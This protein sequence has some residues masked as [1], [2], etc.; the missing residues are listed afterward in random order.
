MQ[1]AQECAGSDVV[2]READTLFFLNCGFGEPLP[3][4]DLVL[5]RSLGYQGIRQDVPRVEVAG[6]LV[7]NVLAE[8][9]VGIFVIPV[10]DEDACHDIAHA[11]A[12][13]IVLRSG[14]SSCAIEAG[15]EEDLSGKR[16]TR[17]PLGWARLVADVS[18]IAQSHG[19][20]QVV[21]GGVSSLSRHAMG[22]LERSHV[23][24]LQVGVG[25][26]QYR[27][28]PPGEALDGYAWREDE[29]RALR[30]AAGGRD[31]WMTESGWSTA[32]RTAG[33]WPLRKTWAFTDDQVAR[34]LRAEM[35]INAEHHA[36]C[37]VTYQ[38]N[39]GPD[40]SNDQDRFGI[41]RSDG[42]LKPQARVLLA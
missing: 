14:E 4:A 39:D 3:A 31:V 21:S 27:S 42:S 25:Y 16:W 11:V 28:T 17:D 32:K 2:L 15:N 6:E 1:L 10:A 18:I 36:R 20:I 41:R 38:L 19:R 35:S 30:D 29:F 22:W 5:I 23:R 34:Y 24:D 8:G 40:P 9:M 37:F 13:Q 33:F 7:D 26:H 12:R